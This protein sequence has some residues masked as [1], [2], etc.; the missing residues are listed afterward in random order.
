[1]AGGFE[2][3]DIAGVF[4]LIAESGNGGGELFGGDGAFKGT[5]GDTAFVGFEGEEELEFVFEDEG[6]DEDGAFFG[7]DDAAGFGIQGFWR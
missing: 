1:M 5:K 2:G 6:I 7:I 3:L 4:Q